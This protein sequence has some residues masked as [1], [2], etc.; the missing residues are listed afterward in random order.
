M[1]HFEINCISFVDW[2]YS[3]RNWKR[4]T[5]HILIKCVERVIYKNYETC[6]ELRLSLSLIQ[7]LHITCFYFTFND[8]LVTFS[9]HF[10][11]FNWPYNNLSHWTCLQNLINFFFFYLQFK[12]RLTETYWKKKSREERFNYKQP[13]K[14]S[15]RNF[16]MCSQ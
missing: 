1:I 15:G 12:F 8:V 4:S 13:K 7:I 16:R 3:K 2:I 9:S 14:W 6:F 10:L 11:R 5:F